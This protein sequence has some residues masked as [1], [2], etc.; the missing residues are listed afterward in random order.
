MV[1]VVVEV[2]M[3]VA[4]VVAVVAVEVSGVTS[5][6]ASKFFIW[7]SIAAFRLNASTSAVSSSTMLLPTLRTSTPSVCEPTDSSG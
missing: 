4:V 7:N 3:V 6:A 2:V 1:V 5:F